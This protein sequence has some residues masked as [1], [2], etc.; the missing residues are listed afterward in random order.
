MDKQINTLH[1]EQFNELTHN[2]SFY[3]STLT[4]HLNNHHHR[5]E[6]PHKHDFNLV[7]LFTQGSGIHEVDF[8][9]Y[10]VQAGSLFYLYPGQVHAWRLSEDIKGYIFFHS[11][12][13]TSELERRGL[14]FFSYASSLNRAQ[15]NVDM[16]EESNI[17][18]PYFEKLLLENSANKYGKNTYLLAIVTSMYIEIYRK[19]LHVIQENTADAKSY[20]NYFNQFNQLL[21]ENFK[22]EK[23]PSLYAQNLHIS[24][25]H[26]NRIL[27]SVIGKSTNDI[28]LDRVILEAQRMLIYENRS[29]SEIANELGYDDYAYFS[30]IFKSRTQISPS[31]FVKN[32]GNRYN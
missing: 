24:P 21:E 14:D 25:K 8:K 19:S 26:L 4:D 16:A 11:G 20:L 5:I 18:I 31:E 29:K 28:I 30:H 9:S 12:I 23:S 3:V 13:F 22:K 2:Q 10:N 15:P 1:I 32:I 27:Q 17:L 6:R 7:V